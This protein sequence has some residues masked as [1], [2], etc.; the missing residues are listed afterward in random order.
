MDRFL[1]SILVLHLE[2]CAER[3][4]WI[5]VYVLEELVPSV[6]RGDTSRSTRGW[7]VLARLTNL[8]VINARGKRQGIWG[9]DNYCWANHMEGRKIVGEDMRWGGHVKAENSIRVIFQDTCLFG[10][11]ISSVPLWLDI[12]LFLLRWWSFILWP[13]L[14]HNHYGF[15]R[16]L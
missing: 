3:W 4:A 13:H 9:P 5:V 6:E 2:L 7:V 8:F 11:Q 14:N 16:S 10:Y 12:Y 1:L 15:L